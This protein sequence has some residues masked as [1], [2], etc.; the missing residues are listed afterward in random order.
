MG[1]QTCATDGSSYGDCVC[2]NEEHDTSS[3]TSTEDSYINRDTMA[4]TSTLISDGTDFKDST[5]VAK[6]TGTETYETDQT[7]DTETE[8]VSEDVND[9]ETSYDT[10]TDINTDEDSE[11]ETGTG[12]ILN[13]Q[14]SLEVP[15]GTIMESQP[16]FT[17]TDTVYTDPT[18]RI[19]L[20]IEGDFEN[21]LVFDKAGLTQSEYQ[22]TKTLKPGVHYTWRVLL[23]G[24]NLSA[25]ENWGGAASFMIRFG[26]ISL[27]SPQGTVEDDQPSFDWSD[28]TSISN[29]RYTFQISDSWTFDTI[30]EEANGLYTSEYTLQNLKLMHGQN[31]WWRVTSTDTNGATD[32]WSG[33]ALI[34]AKIGRVELLSPWNGA[35]VSDT[36]PT[37]KWAANKDAVSYRLVVAKDCEGRE[38]VLDESDIINNSFTP[39]TAFADVNEVNYYWQITPQFADG[40]GDVSRFAMFTLDTTTAG[41]AVRDWLPQDNPYQLSEPLQIDNDEWL[42]IA[43]GVVVNSSQIQSW[44]KISVNGTKDDPVVLNSTT[45]SIKGALSAK[46]I[47]SIRYAEVNGG[48]MFDRLS[49]YTYASLHV[50]DSVV[51]NSPTYLWYPAAS[52]SFYRNIFQRSD[53]TVLSGGNVTTTAATEIRFENNLFTQPTNTSLFLYVVYS[54]ATA[55]LRYNTFATESKTALKADEIEHHSFLVAT[56]NYWG[57]TDPNIID[58]MIFD[59]EDDL[60]MEGTV[61]YTPILAVPHELTPV[62]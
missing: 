53:I 48:K 19:Q 25:E 22:H 57:T 51:K 6:D 1:V 13:Y 7:K 35:L 9:S 52:C 42:R 55:V 33:P 11:S 41:I 29:P 20:S 28:I 31:Y 24:D 58:Q 45:L 44:G 32:I 43:P 37:F 16:L 14:Y 8:S 54:P 5:S 30:L 39:T 10:Q 36:T 59:R 17:W 60:E 23:S 12:D 34:K 61:E 4:D 40:P 3:Q 47:T 26:D 46:A 15:I 2:P 38:I 49:G 62:P 27:T 50:A 56:D 18:Y 21:A